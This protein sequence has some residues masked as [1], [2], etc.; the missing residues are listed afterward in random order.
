MLD[1][2]LL[3]R[4]YPSAD[5]AMLEAFAA[6]AGT[7][8]PNFEITKTRNRLHFFLA[9]I[10]HESGGLRITEENLNY[11]PKRMTQ[12]WPSRFRSL[13]ST[14]GLAHNPRALANNVY[15]GRLGNTGPDDGW[16]YRGRGFIQITGKDGYSK[17]GAVTGLDLVGTPGMANDPANALTVACGF[18][19]WKR[20]NRLCDD[21]SF[22]AV[23]KRINGGTNGLQDR[24][25][26]LERV[27]DIVAWPLTDTPPAAKSLEFTL[28]VARLKAVQV[29]LQALGLYAGSI[30]GI[31]GKMSRKALR[32]FQADN[33]LSGNGHITEETLTALG[34]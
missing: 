24:F 9:Q 1:A 2:T 13:A 16:N 25:H 10:G 8:L 12:V 23:T 4:L 15:G 32:T 6:Q 27:Q 21:G 19:E 18:W 11:S 34:V 28:P 26:W 14:N 33:S 3:H 29:K 7:V 31:F 20:L 5:P 22:V 30:D 17:V